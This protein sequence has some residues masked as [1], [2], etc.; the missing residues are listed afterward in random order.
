MEK[1]CLYQIVQNNMLQYP[2]VDNTDLVSVPPVREGYIDDGHGATGPLVLI[3]F[4][5]GGPVYRTTHT[6]AHRKYTVFKT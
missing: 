6:V 1:H 3:G 5:A 4:S 2:F